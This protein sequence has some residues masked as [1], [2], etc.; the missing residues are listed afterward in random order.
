VSLPFFI[1]RRYF[2]SRRKKNFINIISLLSMA[3]VAFSTAALVI[4]LSVFNGLEGLLRSLYTSFDP[5][6][7]IEAI[8]AKTFEVTPELLGSIKSIEGVDIVT[9]VIEDYA[10][11][12][13][14]DAEMAAIIRGVSENFVDQKRLDGHIVN[15]KLQLH[16][17]NVGFAIVGAGVQSTLSVAVEDDSHALQIFYIKNA[18]TTSMDMSRVYSRKSIRPGAVFSIEKNYDENYIFL[19]L[20]F[21]VDLLDYGNKRT[22]LEV[23]C[24]PEGNVENVRRSLSAAL[25]SS[26][27]VLTNE[28]QHKDLYRLLNMEKLFTF[29]ALSML[30]LVGSINIFFSLMMLAIDKKKDVSILFALGAHPSLVRRVFL[31]EGGIISFLGAGIGLVSGGLICWLQDKFGLVGMGMENAIVASYPVEMRAFDF[32]NIASV[33]VVITLAISFYPAILAARSTKQ[34]GMTKFL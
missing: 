10:Y 14:R 6:L 24:K 7:K 25:G 12:K 2:L 20:D 27:R 15:G 4:V 18:P 30:I 33:V 28:E 5:Q 23:K 21:A 9:E 29:L 17:G 19:P 8:H 16:E 1:A 22:F 32:L 34:T 31:F 11:V 26:F 13:Y 3:G